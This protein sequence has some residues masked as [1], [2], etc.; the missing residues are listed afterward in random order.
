[1]KAQISFPAPLLDFYSPAPSPRLS[2]ILLHCPGRQPMRMASCRQASWWPVGGSGWR[3]E[4]WRAVSW[5]VSSP[6]QCPSLALPVSLLMPAPAKQPDFTLQ[7]LASGEHHQLL[8]VVTAPY[9]YRPLGSLIFVLCTQPTPRGQP[10][11]LSLSIW[12]SDTSNNRYIGRPP[13]L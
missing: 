12:T 4:G 9:S 1:M 3:P 7:H 10:F 11:H 13:S 5:G 8:G 2:W 6:L